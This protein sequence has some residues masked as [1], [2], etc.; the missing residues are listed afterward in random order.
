[1]AAFKVGN[2]RIYNLL[3][4]QGFEPRDALS[5]LESLSIKHSDWWFIL[6]LTGGGIKVPEGVSAFNIL[7]ELGLAA[8]DEEEAYKTRLAQ[9]G[10]GWGFWGGEYST[11]FAQIREKIDQVSQWN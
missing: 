1:M 3:G 4:S 10:H 8:K 5:T 9:W 11:R 6:F 7:V 2:P